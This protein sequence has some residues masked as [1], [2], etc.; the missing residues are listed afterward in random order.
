MNQYSQ[1]NGTVAE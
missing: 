1:S